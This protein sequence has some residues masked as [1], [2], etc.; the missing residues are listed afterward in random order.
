MRLNVQKSLS[1]LPLLTFPVRQK[2]V[3]LIEILVTLIILSIGFLGMASVQLMGAKNVASSNYR[4]LATIYSYDLVERMRS[5]QEGLNANI[6]ENLSWGS[7]P[8]PACGSNCNYSG[9]A[10]RDAWEWSQQLADNLPNGEGSVE[11]NTEG[12]H[13]ITVS[14]D[15]VVRSAT[16][17]DSVQQSFELAVRVD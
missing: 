2:G 11:V 6:Y 13:V 12:M 7:V 10:R 3:S 14:W 16:Q 1:R 17:Q 15:E 8:E 5:N 9:V 4:T